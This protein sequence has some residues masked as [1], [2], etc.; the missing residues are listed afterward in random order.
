MVPGLHLE[1]ISPMEHPGRDEKRQPGAPGKRADL[2]LLDANPLKDI[3]NTRKVSAVILAGRV[4]HRATA[5]KKR[6]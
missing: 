6:K 3:P 5:E 2:V 4:V 1:P